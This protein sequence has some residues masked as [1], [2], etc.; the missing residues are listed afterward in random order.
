[1]NGILDKSRRGGGGEGQDWGG[2]R[3]G[4][5]AGVRKPQFREIKH[6]EGG[7]ELKTMNLSKFL[8]FGYKGKWRNGA[9]AGR[10][11][12]VKKG[13]FPR[14]ETYQGL[15]SHLSSSVPSL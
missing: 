4:R 13:F 10:Q 8:E 9:V 6:K 2:G 11:C 14:W 15:C 5:V 1:M 12:R 3:T 7:E